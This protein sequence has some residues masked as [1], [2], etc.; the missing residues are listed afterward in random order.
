MVGCAVAS[1]AVALA[2]TP[3]PQVELYLAGSTAQDEALENLMRLTAGISGAPNICEPGTLDIYRGKIDGTAK[4]T[5][6]CRTSGNVPG[7]P[8]GLRLAVHKS[9]GSSG[10]GVT[11]VS[12]G[13]AL[14]YIDLAN[15]P[16]AASC[17]EG[18]Q[19]RATADFVAYRNHTGCDG[20]GKKAVPRAGMSDV[21]P[22]LVGGISRPLTVR[23]QTQ[24]VWGLPVSKNLRN[25]LQAVQ[26]LVRSSVPHDDPS[27]E[28]EAAMPNLTRAQVAGLFAGTIKTWDQLYDSQGSGLPNSRLLA[29]GAPANPDASG[30]S[31]GGYRPDRAHGN[32]VYICRRVVSSGTQASYETHYLRNRCVKGAPPFVPPNDGSDLKTGG[33]VN[34]LV[35]VAGPAGNVFA[36]SGTGDVR[37]CLDAHEQFNRWAVGI[38]STENIGNNGNREFRYVKVDGSAPTLLNAHAGRWTHVSEQ[39]MQWLRSFDGSLETTHEGRVLA[40]IATNMGL[41][42][43]IRALNTG[44][45]HSW[46]QA[47]YLAPATGRYQP[48]AAPVTA[49]SLRADPVAG[50]SRGLGGE[51]NNCSEPVAVGR[52]PL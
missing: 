1:Q 19:E 40:F 39:S 5:F 43:V 34:K 12:G 47:G 2:P 10:E 25:A 28:T 52:T 35:R 15:L 36:G 13:V 17:R 31:P 14:P 32:T 27:R 9:S 33:D 3:G 18:A 20:G 45:A 29:P 6:Y 4:R 49:S 21:E 42:R 11:P 24:L 48:P 46:G 30:A 23:T 38:L 41:P 7:L 16:V 26:G 22:A 44:F 8:A 51:A 37:D 50:I